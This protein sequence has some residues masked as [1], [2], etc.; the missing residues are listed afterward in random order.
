[1]LRVEIVFTSFS[2]WLYLLLFVN[3]IVCAIAIAAATK[4]KPRPCTN[5]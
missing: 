2:K 1:V 4:R 5:C 3:L